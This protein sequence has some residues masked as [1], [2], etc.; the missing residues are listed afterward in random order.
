MVKDREAWHASV[1]GVT[2]SQ[3]WLCDWTTTTEST[4]RMKYKKD[5][6]FKRGDISVY[7]SI[8]LHNQKSDL[9]LLDF[10]GGQVVKNLPTSARAQVWSLD[11]EDHTCQRKTAQVP[12]LLKPTQSCALQWEKPPQWEVAHIHPNWRKPMC[13]NLDLVQPKN[14]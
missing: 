8:E 9:K 13:S 1:H 14:K 6:R 5:V 2:K 10:A 12:Q 3:T 4:G 11:Q 7:I